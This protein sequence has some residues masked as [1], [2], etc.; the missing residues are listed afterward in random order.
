MGTL[1]HAI[2]SPLLEKVNLLSIDD[3]KKFSYN[4]TRYGIVFKFNQLVVLKDDRIS[5]PE[6]KSEQ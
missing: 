1:P 2:F 6:M 3:Y 4:F 5:L